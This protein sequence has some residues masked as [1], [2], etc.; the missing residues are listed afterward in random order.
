MA[1]LNLVLSW[2][3]LS[4]HIEH[5]FYFWERKID[6]RRL[7]EALLRRGRRL[8]WCTPTH[9]YPNTPSALQ[10]FTQTH[11]HTHTHTQTHTHTH[12]HIH[13]VCPDWSH[14]STGREKSEKESHK[15]WTEIL[16]GIIIKSLAVL[17]HHKL[18]NESSAKTVNIS[19]KQNLHEL[20]R[21][22]RFEKVKNFND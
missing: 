12:Y 1:K 17:I 15:H 13:I 4:G 21:E 19:Q 16:L 18:L 8:P 10:A 3:K 5:F 14:Q 7:S 20:K 6:M 2:E 22:K 11:T 9:T